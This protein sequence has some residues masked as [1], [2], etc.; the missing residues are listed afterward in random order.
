MRRW[1]S[2]IVIVV[3]ALFACHA[4]AA[5][6]GLCG[7]YAHKRGDFYG[8][9]FSGDQTGYN[10]AKAYVGTFG[11]IFIYPGCENTITIGTVPDSV[12]VQ[13]YVGGRLVTYGTGSVSRLGPFS[14]ATFGGA[15]RII[16]GVMFTQDDTGVRKAV[17]EVKAA[18]G[19]L[20]FMT[21]G[22][23]NWTTSVDITDATG[24]TIAGAGDSTIIWGNYP[25]GATAWRVLNA[26][27]SIVFRDFTYDGDHA[28]NTSGHAFDFA[29]TSRD[30]TVERVTIRDTNG[31][32][33]T[34]AAPRTR[35][36]NCKMYFV[37]TQ[38]ILLYNGTAD[39]SEVTD[40]DITDAR[41]TSLNISDN[42]D[43]V[44]V[45][46]NKFINRAG[47]LNYNTVY[48]CGGGG[49]YLDFVDNFV[50]GSDSAVLALF[51][52]D[53]SKIIGNTFTNGRIYSGLYLLRGKAVLVENNLCTWNIHSGI[54]VGFDS[55]DETDILVQGNICRNNQG[56]GISV[57]P[58]TTRTF[59]NIVIMG[60][61][62]NNNGGQG[63]L[64]SPASFASTAYIG[65]NVLIGNSA[66]TSLSATNWTYQAP[67]N[68]VGLFLGTYTNA[69]LGTP[70]NGT[71]RYCSDCTKAT[72][73]AGGGTGSFAFRKVGAW[74][75]N[76]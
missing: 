76:P 42:T 2:T 1:L 15:V 32:G 71:I 11:D 65:D 41:T 39:S 60:N 51:G 64:V 13:Q 22:R 26:S 31:G 14:G 8:K 54:F 3:A 4:F 18:G 57:N 50:S 49:K 17:A 35:V 40:N 56:A 69:T 6:S 67:S 33:V 44:K 52:P 5:Y 72:P 19:G 68:D 25:T 47:L 34:S 55:G 73:C 45:R 16:D 12:I 61:V 36:R 23:Y 43:Y 20:V 63:I 27:S 29:A 48:A 21:R 37:G 58:S 28:N 10:A 66:P 70:P 75:C 53:S 62:S 9:N 38:G 30:I 24:I 59:T 74:D 7:V 46:G